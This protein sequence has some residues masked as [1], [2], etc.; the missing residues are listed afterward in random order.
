MSLILFINTL[1][2]GFW[3][4]NPISRHRTTSAVNALTVPISF[5]RPSFL[6]DVHAVQRLCFDQQTNDHYRT[7][8]FLQILLL[9]TE[10]TLENVG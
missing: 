3:V 10:H 7:S 5:N 2:G 4:A 8:L 6:I 9:T 1:D